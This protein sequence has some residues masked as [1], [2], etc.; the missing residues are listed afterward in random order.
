MFSGGIKENIVLNWVT[1]KVN[2]YNY[3][4]PKNASTIKFHKIKVSE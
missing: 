4:K 3:E 1:R 2:I